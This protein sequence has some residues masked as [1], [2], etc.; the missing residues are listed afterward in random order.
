TTV[1]MMVNYGSAGVDF[2]NGAGANTHL[3]SSAPGRLT[4]ARSNYVAMGGYYAPSIYPQYKGTFYYN[5]ATKVTGITDGSS[6][7]II[8]GEVFGGWN[9]WGG[10]GGIPDGVMTYS[11]VCGFNYSGF[12]T[13]T[14]NPSLTS[15]DSAWAYFSS[16]HTSIVNF[17]WGDGSVRAL[18]PSID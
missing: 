18:N 12:G 2:P 17:L 10:S 5:S 7:T 14:A 3:F 11:W 4:I 1:C 8:F 6:N 16:R 15:S 13:P 9:A